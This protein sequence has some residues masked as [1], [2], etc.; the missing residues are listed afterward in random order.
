MVG[1]MGLVDG[2]WWMVD[3]GWWMADGGW[4]MADGG[5][6]MACVGCSALG[7]VAPQAFLDKMFQN[8]VFVECSHV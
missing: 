7:F 1:M 2:G 6:W 4:R 5:W 3:G 8:S